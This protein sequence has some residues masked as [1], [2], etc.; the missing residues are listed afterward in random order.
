MTSRLQQGL[1]KFDLCDEQLV[2]H[3]LNHTQKYAR[4]GA[5]RT[6]I[7]VISHER[8]EARFKKTRQTIPMR[9]CSICSQAVGRAVGWLTLQRQPQLQ[10]FYH[11]GVGG[12]NGLGARWSSVKVRRLIDSSGFFLFFPRFGG[13]R[14]RWYSQLTSAPSKEISNSSRRVQFSRRSLRNLK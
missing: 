10:L 8:I 2:L 11:R 12:T 9:R 13:G 1:A 5:I 14:Q 4:R 7:A 3:Y 6:K